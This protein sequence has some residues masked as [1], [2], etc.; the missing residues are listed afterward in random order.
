MRPVPAGA[1]T[2]AL[3][4]RP[5]VF[6]AA[7]AAGDRAHPGGAHAR[8]TGGGAGDVDPRPSRRPSRIRGACTTRDGRVLHVTCGVGHWFP[9]RLGCPP[10]L[11][12]LELRRT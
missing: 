11:V 9:V 6:D 5:G 3:S 2:I 12:L 8:R 4:H 1:F 10:E 7:A